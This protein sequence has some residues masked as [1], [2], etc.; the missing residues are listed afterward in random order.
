ML[1]G[2]TVE[3]R[4]QKVSEKAVPAAADVPGTLVKKTPLPCSFSH[5][6]LGHQRGVQHEGKG[7]PK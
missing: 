5:H 2:N 6:L 7:Q 1:E 3:A 4:S